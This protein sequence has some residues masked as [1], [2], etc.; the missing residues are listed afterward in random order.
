MNDIVPF[1]FEGKD[2]RT[3][4]DELGNPWFV[5]K[6]VCDILLYTN[7]NRALAMHCKGVTKCY[8]LLTPG[9]YQ[10]V[11][12]IN[13]PDLY[14]L[15]ASSNLPDAERFERWVFEE[16]L[17]TIRKTGSYSIQGMPSNKDSHFLISEFDVWT[18]F[19]GRFN[20]TGNQALLAASKSCKK[21]YGIDPMETMGLNAL[22]CQVQSVDVTPTQIGTELCIGARKVNELLTTHGFQ[23]KVPG[24]KYEP[25]EKGLE[26][27]VIKDTNKRHSNGTPVTQLLWKY[28]IVDPLK[29]AMKHQ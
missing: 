13:E 27:A 11:R 16:V 29:Y 18:E 17:P 5:G 3:I 25:T 2:I 9:G 10:E 23:T 6:D 20:I 7:H 14:R 1:N 24:G 22:E 15:L 28:N 19:A 12:I 26:Y 8:P 21:L 4:T